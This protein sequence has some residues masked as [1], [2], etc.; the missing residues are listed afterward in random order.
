M[1]KI[2]IAW[3]IL[4]GMFLL[5][6]AMACSVQNTADSESSSD[7]SSNRE[8]LSFKEESS[9]GSSSAAYETYM[10]SADESS[11][12]SSRFSK[13]LTSSSPSTGKSSNAGK[14]SVTSQI[15]L[16]SKETIDSPQKVSSAPQA[17]P[18]DSV[19]VYITRT[20]KRYHYENPCGNGTYYACT[21][22]EALRRGLTPCEKCVLH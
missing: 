10:E 17:D 3:S 21:L 12:E 7:P 18:N 9:Q 2:K 22:S 11:A 15:S 8:I 4:I 20:G 5:V 1:K 16:A 6:S 19:I 14:A 13:Q